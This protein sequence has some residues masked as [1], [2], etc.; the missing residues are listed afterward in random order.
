MV[1]DPW[2]QLKSETINGKLQ[3]Q[4]AFT[5]QASLTSVVE[6]HIVL[7]GSTGHINYPPFNMSML[8][9]LPANEWLGCLGFQRNLRGV[10]SVCV[11]N[12]YQLY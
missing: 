4:I 9:M 8:Y 2:D 12:G 3:T 1:S 10:G 5:L 7:L 6:F 11:N